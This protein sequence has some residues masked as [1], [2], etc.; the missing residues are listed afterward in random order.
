LR[1]GLAHLNAAILLLDPAYE[2]AGIPP[3]RSVALSG[4]R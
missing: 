2:L 1:A 4:G 3:K